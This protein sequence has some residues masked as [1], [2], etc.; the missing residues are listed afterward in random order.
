MD[1]VDSEHYRYERELEWLLLS[2]AALQ[3]YGIVLN[4]L[5]DQ[6]LPLSE[7]LFYW[8]DVQTSYR[9]TLYYLLQTFPQRMIQVGQ[10]IYTESRRRLEDLKLSEAARFIRSPTSSGSSSRSRTPPQTPGRIYQHR[11]AENGEPEKWTNTAQ[12]F[13]GLAKNTIQ[14]RVYAYRI[15]TVSPFSIVRNEI[16]Q[17]QSQIQKLREMQAAALGVLIGEGLSFEFDEESEEWRSIIER[18]VILMENVVRNVYMVDH[19]LEEFE[20]A[21]FT[22]SRDRRSLGEDT[23]QP[24]ELRLS[25][26]NSSDTRAST[27]ALCKQIQNILLNHLPAQAKASRGLIAAHGRP[28]T[29]IRYWLPATIIL[30][31][32]S[33]I[34]RILV[35]R[36]AEIKTWI[37]ELG[38]T[39]LDF[40]KNWV[41]EP[42]KSVIN[43]IRHN[44][45]SEVALMSRKSLTADMDSLER[46][47]VDFAI[48]NPD[49]TSNTSGKLSSSELELVRSNVKQGDLTP[50]LKAYE[51]DLR[52]PFQGAVKGELVRALL[53]Q[54]QKTKVDVEVAISG[55][56]RLLKS[57]ELVFG[58]VSLTPGLFISVVTLRWMADVF[59]GKAR[60]NAKKQGSMMRRLRKVDKILT[61]S[62]AICGDVQDGGRLNYKE[63]GL[64]LCEVHVLRQ[65]ASKV[66]SREILGE[67]NADLEDLVDVGS[68]VKSQLRVLDRIR[69]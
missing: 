41:I 69:W 6:T 13:Y 21:V 37:R 51:H 12:K 66:L 61:A 31:S 52:K 43:T 11:V 44:E 42:T 2:K 28:G 23:S 47:V 22:F 29:I 8:D 38:A 10:E 39:A 55:I 40:W 53:I 30:L 48:D 9:Y 27:A 14:E 68:G 65:N 16:R 46:M 32:S 67:F 19:S 50:V 33:T 63:H 49:T 1:E 26:S 4:S 54:I 34:L 62:K 18:A 3:A 25:I 36:E 17:K 64:L 58:F 20:D 35:N 7:D 59:R 56:D 15:S 5:V 24:D 57:Q 45:D 60:R